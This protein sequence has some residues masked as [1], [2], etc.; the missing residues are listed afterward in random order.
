MMKRIL[1]FMLLLVLL[2]SITGCRQLTTFRADD[3]TGL[4][5]LSEHKKEKIFSEWQ[6]HPDAQGFTW[7]SA[8]SPNGFRYCGTYHGYDIIYG[9][10]AFSSQSYLDLDGKVFESPA[11]VLLLAYK[12]GEFFNVS[13]L[14]HE[15]KLNSDD[16]S[17]IHAFYLKYGELLR[18]NK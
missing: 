8:E 3:E 17:Q 15:G 2:L 14:F 5:I 7:F 1:L 11:N 16:I 10:Y 18:D 4:P 9:N 6:N 13:V 12:N